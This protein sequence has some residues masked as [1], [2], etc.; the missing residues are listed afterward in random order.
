VGASNATVLVQFDAHP[1]GY[2]VICAALPTTT[3]VTDISQITSAATATVYSALIFSDES[4]DTTVTVAGLIPS[5]NYYVYCTVEDTFG[6]GCESLPEVVDS[7]ISITT[8]CCKP[9]T[10]QPPSFVPGSGPNPISSNTITFS[11]DGNDNVTIIP[12]VNCTGVKNVT[13]SAVST[14]SSS[15]STTGNFVVSGVGNGTCTITITTS[16][17]SAP[18]HIGDPII[19][20]LGSSQ[21]QTPPKILYFLFRDPGTGADL[22]FSAPTDRGYTVVGGANYFKCSK[23]LT[24]VGVDSTICTWIDNTNLR[25]YFPTM[26]TGNKSALIVPG[27]LA[28][29]RANAIKGYCANNNNCPNLFSGAMSV[30]GVAPN[31][32]VVPL[33]QWVTPKTLV[34]GKDLYI[35]ASTSFGNAGRDWRDIRFT[36]TSTTV[37]V[38]STTE[39]IAIQTLLS[40]ITDLMEPKKIPWDL[41]SPSA[42]YVFSLYLRNYYNKEAIQSLQV[43]VIDEDT[44]PQLSFLRVVD[45]QFF[46]SSTMEIL[47]S[48]KNPSPSLGGLKFA[49]SVSKGS[50]VMPAIVSTSDNPAM[51]SLDPYTLTAGF[52]YTFTCTVT[53]SAGKTAMIS[54]AYG[55]LYG[56]IHAIIDGGYNRV[57]PYNVGFQLDGSTSYD[58]Y[59]GGPSP[60]TY[61]WECTVVSLDA[62]GQSCNSVFGNISTTQGSITLTDGSLAADYS[63]MF[64]LTV[65]TVSTPHRSNITNVTVTTIGCGASVI[66]SIFNPKSSRF[67]QD[68]KMALLATVS[69][70]AGD[71]Y[72][73]NWT[74]ANDRELYTGIAGVALS[75]FQGSMTFTSA[76]FI[77]LIPISLMPAALEG[78]RIYTFTINVFQPEYP[79]CMASASMNLT[80]NMSPIPG[81][82]SVSPKIGT[83][84]ATPFTLKATSWT[85][86]TSDY[87]LT[88]SFYYSFPSDSDVSYPLSL[89][90]DP[91]LLT[92][93]LP[94]GSDFDDHTIYLYLSIADSFNCSASTSSTVQVYTTS[95]SSLNLTAVNNLV[96]SSLEPAQ[97]ASNWNNLVGV[98]NALSHSLNSVNCTVEVD[99]ST[100]NRASCAG[101]AHTCSSCLPGF[102]GQVGDSNHPC[103]YSADWASPLETMARRLSDVSVCIVDSDCPLAPLSQCINSTCVDLPKQCPTSITNETCSGHG[104][105]FALD[106]TGNPVDYCGLMDQGC[107]VLCVCDAYHGGRDCSYGL[108]EAAVRLQA[109][110]MMCQAVDKLVR[111]STP[112]VTFVSQLSTTLYN[113]FDP[114]ELR[115]VDGISTCADAMY[116]LFSAAAFANGNVQARAGNTF[117]LNTT[118]GAK[119]QTSQ[120]IM[121]NIIS[122]YVV[123]MI[124]ST[125][126]EFAVEA[127]TTFVD[128]IGRRSRDLREV[129]TNSKYNN[130]PA[131]M[132]MYINSIHLGMVPGES[133]ITVA[134]DNIRAVIRFDPIEDYEGM[135]LQTPLTSDEFNLPAAYLTNVPRATLQMPSNG[136]TSCMFSGGYVPVS[137]VAWKYPPY[138]HSELII[139]NLGRFSVTDPATLLTRYAHVSSSNAFAQML[140]A[141]TSSYLDNR[142]YQYDS[143]ELTY[144]FTEPH[145]WTSSDGLTMGSKPQCT[146]WSEYD[147]AYKACSVVMSETGYNSYNVTYTSTDIYKFCP[148][149]YP[150]DAD[151]YSA[152]LYTDALAIVEMGTALA[153]DIGILTTAISCAPIRSVSNFVAIG[154]FFLIALLAV[155]R[156]MD[157]KDREPVYHL[158]KARPVSR[159]TT[160]TVATTVESQK[161]KGEKKDDKKK[162]GSVDGPQLSSADTVVV[163]REPVVRP[164][165]DV[166]GIVDDAL[167]TNRST[168]LTYLEKNNLKFLRYH[169]YTRFF[170]RSNTK[171]R[172]VSF[173]TLV[174]K[175]IMLLYFTTEYYDYFYAADN[176]CM[177]RAMQAGFGVTPEQLCLESK[178]WYN[179][180][181]SECQWNA[182]GSL[183]TRA[184]PPHQF[185]LYVAIAAIVELL[186]VVPFNIMAWLIT[187]CHKRPDFAGKPFLY[188]AC[189]GWLKDLVKQR[190]TKMVTKLPQPANTESPR[191]QMMAQPTPRSAVVG[192]MEAGR[193]AAPANGSTESGDPRMNEEEA[194]MLESYVNSYLH[195][196]Y[197]DTIPSATR[198]QLRDAITQQLRARLRGNATLASGLSATR[199]ESRRLVDEISTSSAASNDAA[200]SASLQS[201]QL[202][203]NLALEHLNPIQRH[204][205]R[206]KFHRKNERMLLVAKHEDIRGKVHPALWLLIWI[207]LIAVNLFMIVEVFM[208]TRK[209]NCNMPVPWFTTFFL[210]VLEDMVV[211]SS[212]RVY[213]VFV[214]GVES[215]ELVLERIAAVL[216]RRADSMGQAPAS[217]SEEVR[218]AQHLSPALRA[219]RHESLHNLPI[220]VLLGQ[221]DDLDI[222]RFVGR[223]NLPWSTAIAMSIAVCMPE[224]MNDVDPLSQICYMSAIVPLLWLVF[225]LAN[226]LGYMVSPSLVLVMYAFFATYITA[227]FMKHY[228]HRQHSSSSK[229]LM[230]MVDKI[231]DYFEKKKKLE[232]EAEDSVANY[233]DSANGRSSNIAN[234][235]MWRRRFE[236]NV[237]TLYEEFVHNADS[238]LQWNFSDGQ[239]ARRETTSSF[240]VAVEYIRRVLE[241]LRT[242]QP[243]LL[244]ADEAVRQA[245]SA[246][247]TYRPNGQLLNEL[248]WRTMADSIHSEVMRRDRL[249]ISHDEFIDWFHRQCE[250][251][252]NTRAQLDE[253]QDPSDRTHPQAPVAPAPSP[254]AIF[255]HSPQPRSPPG[256]VT[257]GPQANS[258]N[259]AFTGVSDTQQAIEK[260]LR[261][262]RGLDDDGDNK[263]NRDDALKLV[264]YTFQI[265]YPDGLGLNREE[266]AACTSALVEFMSQH[267]QG[268]LT[269]ETYCRWVLNMRHASRVPLN[270]AGNATGSLDRSGEAMPYPAARASSASPSRV[271]LPFPSAGQSQGGPPVDYYQNQPVLAPMLMMPQSFGGGFGQFAQGR[272]P[273]EFDDDD[274]TIAS[275]KSAVT[276]FS[277]VGDILHHA[278]LKFAQLDEDHDGYVTANE[279]MDLIQW[280]YV[281]YFPEGK[282]VS[283]ERQREATSLLVD[284]VNSSRTRLLGVEQFCRWI[285]GL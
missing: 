168:V 12:K 219:A 178:P 126:Y 159:T 201:T 96:E 27:G 78:Q 92:T 116:N 3:V 91:Q 248:E 236:E 204:A 103:I 282:P 283:R 210:C 22:W 281:T 125:A 86:D 176:S 47:V 171:R 127:K 188:W 4:F 259:P 70:N 123:S 196:N 177:L 216:K 228:T 274:V 143:F 19:A 44:V 185:A 77:K 26:T 269:S 109:R 199:Q 169:L 64:K 37:G 7:K 122:E 21:K 222:H 65:T 120:Q 62:H 113:V 162:E 175:I 136:F 158:A 95:A 148:S 260:G 225:M 33:I 182:N 187:Y 129:V 184:A 160:S 242:S 134:L 220:A 277:D 257:N 261:M 20:Q 97:W 155:F 87:P 131:A 48:A 181:K 41:F 191:A 11:F 101:T 83:G 35:D 276:T 132:Q 112:S 229:W 39:F 240:E 52:T 67:N 212:A 88:Y 208:W 211:Y 142:V 218:L 69:G 284:I 153:Q 173:F 100:L 198:N 94:D 167:M 110:T 108:D 5:S 43:N 246:F 205:M 105:C 221:V 50:T 63:Y 192:P 29:V 16:G 71:Q 250:E 224:W 214:H 150:A 60:L 237:D 166:A 215:S 233:D 165:D 14:S 121:P 255:I 273:S 230:E 275:Q 53:S 183:C 66:P 140:V 278:R 265:Y 186:S 90:Q 206:L 251:V 247:Q 25:I 107:S 253:V 135:T 57:L 59:L 197:G 30:Y 141:A 149:L 209:E 139:S 133:P 264:M 193:D 1:P 80:I 202:V 243:G 263:V 61:L 207:L 213:A 104:S 2:R 117:S 8:K 6:D 102:I 226:F 72:S 203:Q 137:I 114:Y 106:N 128:Q 164:S 270:L 146:E 200:L 151:V 254:A 51:M 154:L 285:Q 75:S 73:Y 231:D 36:V 89:A 119:Q 49:W 271:A 118:E 10:I 279:V 54:K 144:P 40:E 68:A 147:Q 266:Q 76:E 217:N 234:P 190:K 262:F 124:V 145:T 56:Y 180:W 244:T 38:Q 156:W 189:F 31:Q 115:G 170:F 227:K 232:Q 45:S 152:S 13:V 163:R 28:I 9:I 268:M 17:G 15:S 249:S 161:G 241:T 23:L 74:I 58:D 195:T 267:P 138:P 82:F 157:T 111:Y 42:T 174:S 34:Y 32:G 238:E 46:P 98:M 84:L 81:T 239:A 93:V 256:S 280:T 245:S 194:R 172:V 223:D 235:E 24:F 99:C 85:D 130:I 79:S 272:V 18:L 55:V 258:S 252:A 179:Y